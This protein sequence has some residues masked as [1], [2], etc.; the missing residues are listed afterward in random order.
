MRVLHVIPSVSL[1]DG[2]PSIA[3]AA[4]ERALTS[5]G[6]E[7]TTA[8]TDSELSI[9]ETPVNGATRVYA[10]KRSEFYKVAPAIVP[11]LINNIPKFDVV[12]IH[13]LFSFTSTVAAWIARSRQVPYIVRPLG[14][15]TSYG[16]MRRR[17][18]FKKISLAVAE[19]HII[20]H[21]AALH[22]TSRREWEEADKLNIPFRG[23]VIPIGLPAQPEGCRAELSSEFPFLCGRSIILYISRLDPKKN[24][25]GLIAA[26]ASRPKV[27]EAA[28]LVI[29]GSG[30]PEYVSRLKDLANGAGVASEVVWLGHVT[31]KRKSAA[32]AAADLFVLPSFSENFG[33]AAVEA[34]YAGLPC[35]LGEGVAIASEVQASGAGL[36]VAADPVALG[37]AMEQ[38]L[39]DPIVRNEMGARGKAFALR[40]YSLDVMA[41]RLVSLYGE[42]I[43]SAEFAR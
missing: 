2:G 37:A 43:A 34:L 29:A 23:A 14:T 19:R 6:V 30:D 18:W 42:I 39:S 35:V 26:F 38:I 15:L 24:I 4:M 10:R 8:T 40:E 22:F 36:A 25:E 27:R 32:F 11:W 28:A 9:L 3:I 12:H 16:V 7:V 41:D 21:A 13:A 1:K 20:E 17:P 31:G 5:A 33:I